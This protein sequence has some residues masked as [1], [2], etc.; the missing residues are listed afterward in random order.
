MHAI[1]PDELRLLLKKYRIK[2]RIVRDLRFTPDEID[3]ERREML[4][5]LCRSGSEGLLIVE[6]EGH[7]YLMPYSL[8]KRLV[9]T[10]TGRSRPIT[11]DFCHTWQ[12][13]SHAAAITFSQ[14]DEQRS[15]SFLCCADLQCSLHIRNLTPEA[16]LSRTQLHE[17][18][19]IDMR[20]ARLERKLAARAHECGILADD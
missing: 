4:P 11:C 9:D 13:G 10:R 20:V 5:I 18:M 17:D 16:T 19:T 14:R 6:L 2:P 7:R 1:T 15:R 8:S 12:R 3:W